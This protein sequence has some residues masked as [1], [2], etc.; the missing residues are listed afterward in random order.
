[1]I[2]HFRNAF[3]SG[4][5]ILIPL[6]VTIF[7]IRFLLKNIGEPSSHLFFYYLDP[8]TRHKPWVDGVLRIISTGVV[9]IL[10]TLLGYLSKYFLGKIFVKVTEKII[11]SVPFIKTVYK[12]AKQIVDT[13]R[14]QNKAIFQQV[15]LV[16]YPRTGCYALGFLTGTAR[17]ETQIKTGKTIVNVF[18]PTTPNPTSGFLLLIPQEDILALE[19][20]VSDGMKLIIS[21]G[22]VVP[23]YNPKTGKTEQFETKNL[24]LETP[25]EG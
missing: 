1:M 8:V 15:V 21:G 5:A 20:S 25:D 9:V 3:I 10:I 7:V 23:A 6:G 16:E 13:F 19:M 4:L 17:G 2:R 14:E 24:S 11:T 18:I 22:A 12:T